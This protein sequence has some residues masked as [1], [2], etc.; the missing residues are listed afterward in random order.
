MQSVRYNRIPRLLPLVAT[1][2]AMA[3]QA[4]VADDRATRS[5]A[6]VRMVKITIEL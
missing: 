6:R 1:G 4:D 2:G 5:V 3:T